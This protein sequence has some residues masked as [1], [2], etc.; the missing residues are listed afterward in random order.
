MT[1][2]KRVIAVCCLIAAALAA[3]GAGYYMHL[4]KEN[5][6]YFD[7]RIQGEKRYILDNR[8]PDGAILTYYSDKP[9]QDGKRYMN[10]YFACIAAR[11]LLQGEVTREQDTAVRA[12]LSWH[13]A[14]LEQDGG[15]SD[16]DYDGK[17]AKWSSRNDADSTDSYAALYLI[18][19]SEYYGKTRDK[20]FIREIGGKISLAAG[21]MLEM[22]QPDGLMAM[23][24]AHPVRYTMDNAEVNLALRKLAAL[25]KAVPELQGDAEKISAALDRNTKAIAALLREKDSGEYLVG[26]DKKGAAHKETDRNRVYPFWT[27]QLFPQLFGITDGAKA[28][29]DSFCESV[30][31]TDMSFRRDDSSSYWCALLCAA[32]QNKDRARVDEYLAAYDK[33]LGDMRGYPYYCAESGWAIT[34]YELMKY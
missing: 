4:R 29:Y 1:K 21:K 28:L 13:S 5:N 10:P 17:N 19:V 27:A 30:S 7:A 14:H 24:D 11:G 6:E 23:S 31:W 16:Y 2:R 15:M 3:A 25:Y 32:A 26:L 34:A 20:E 9:E 33:A 12:Y 8:T 22:Q 18:L